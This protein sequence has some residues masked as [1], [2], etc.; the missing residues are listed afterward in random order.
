MK[1]S[2]SKFSVSKQSASK[3]SASKQSASKKSASKQSEH[4][5]KTH[6][7][8][9]QNSPGLHFNPDICKKKY[10]PVSKSSSTTQLVISKPK[11]KQSKSKVLDS[12]HI[13]G[14]SKKSGTK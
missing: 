8:R 9:S 6:N 3:Q 12:K 13:P 10:T 4:A 14:K 1:Q 11:P 5:M 2:S 7:T